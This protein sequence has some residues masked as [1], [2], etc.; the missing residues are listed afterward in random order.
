MYL[1]SSW[2]SAAASPRR[3][4]D[5][6]LSVESSLCRALC[7]GARQLV[8]L[9]GL[10]HGKE[11]SQLEVASRTSPLMDL[12]RPHCFVFVVDVAVHLRPFDSLLCHLV[13]GQLF[14]ELPGYC[15]RARAVKMPRDLGASDAVGSMLA[16]ADSVRASSP[17]ICV[18]RDCRQTGGRRT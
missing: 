12:L 6:P 7:A 13:R 10:G 5:R 4:L 1:S 18:C 2:R 9:V 3:T 14:G 8:E 17:R 15:Y 16:S 11:F